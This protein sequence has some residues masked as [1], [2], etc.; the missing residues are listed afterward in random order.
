MAI[1]EY[2]KNY[3]V[4]FE[5]SNNCPLFDTIGNKNETSLAQHQDQL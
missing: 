5:I 2:D 4:R 3:S 1:S